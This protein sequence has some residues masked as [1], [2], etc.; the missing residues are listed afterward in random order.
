MTRGKYENDRMT[1]V[2]YQAA[3]P[4]DVPEM[5]DLFLATLSDMYTRNNISATLPPRAEMLLGYEH[6]CSTGVFHVA[7]LEGT[8]IA[9]AGAVIRDHIWYLSAFWARPDLQRM[10][11]GMSLLRRVWEAGNRAGATTF[12]TWSSID[13]TAMASYMKL[14]MLPGYE[15]F[16]FE[17]TPQLLPSVPSGY[18]TVSLERHVATELDRDVRGTGREVDHDF[19]SGR[20]GFQGQ[21]VLRN[22]NVIGYYYH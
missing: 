14:G 16:R 4:E 12:F 15:I 5:T 1:Q 19:W 2:Q 8:I 13:L 7:E 21:Q 9:I 10:K 17:G 20:A 11:I 6:I 3:R 22:G 18:E